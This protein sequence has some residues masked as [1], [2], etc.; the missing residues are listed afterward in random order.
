MSSNYRFE[1]LQV[2]AGQ[3]ADGV[4]RA[5]A[6][7]IYQTTSYVFDD[8]QY[9]ADLFAFK[10]P[11]YMYSRMHNPTVEVFEER[12]AALEGG[13]GALAL[14]SG[15]AAVSYAIQNIAGMGDHIVSALTL[16]GGTYNLFLHTFKKLGI[17]VTFVDPD[18]PENFRAAIRG[19]T[20]A[21]YLESL[22][23]P[24]CNITD[25]E[26]IA[27]IAHAAG[28]PVIVDNTF[29]PP[30][31]F[32]PFRHGADI[33]IHSAT[34]F[35]GGHGTT[36]G[37]VIVDSGNFDW[38]G[39]GRFP[40]MTEPDESYHGITWLGEFGP[41]GYL[42]KARFTL[43]RDT[44]ACISPFSAFLL[45]QGL[46]TLSLRVERHMENARAAAA[47]LDKHPGVE[48][49]NHPSL[50][51]NAYHSLAKK[52]FPKYQGSIFSI[53]V[54]GGKEEARAFVERL[55]LFTHLANVA[56]AKS[57]AIHPGSTTHSQMTNSEL[58]ECGITPNTV[59]LSIGIEHID[60]ILEDLD[61]ALRG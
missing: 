43:L 2:H 26:C 33:L 49:V 37:G 6:V 50:P 54:K 4:T 55:K 35:I 30:C 9:A 57:L 25:M 7:P 45:L 14:S 40:G 8:A 13:V 19:S 58:L 29:A 53:G 24:N 28:V 15:S 60:D 39:S 22:G 52:Y 12:I 61:Q 42:N 3:K 1:T 48:F 18:D 11:G 31:M 17:D 59:R 38:K 10:A 5:C 23:N 27:E 20:K 41:L 16:Y 47:F 56:D 36:L 46:E 51:G 44:G 34:K 21:V 32:R